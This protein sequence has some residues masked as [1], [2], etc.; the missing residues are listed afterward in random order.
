MKWTVGTVGT[1]GT[2]RTAKTGTSLRQSDS[3]L[4]RS[5]GNQRNQQNQRRQVR[6]VRQPFRRRRNSTLTTRTHSIRPT[7]PSNKSAKPFACRRRKRARRGSHGYC[8]TADARR[9]ERAWA[10]SPPSTRADVRC[11]RTRTNGRRRKRR[12]P[13]RCSCSLTTLA[14]GAYGSLEPDKTAHFTA[15]LTRTHLQIGNY[16][17]LNAAKNIALNGLL[18]LTGH[19][20]IAAHTDAEMEL[21]ELENAMHSA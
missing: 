9:M 7:P 5:S 13:P 18:I 15:F 21:L 10:F 14:R 11:V 8:K 12:C 1:V 19:Q 2:T 16:A 4:P 17:L 6:R 3:A 20:P